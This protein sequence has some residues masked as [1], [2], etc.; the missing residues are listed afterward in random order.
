MKFLLLG[1]SFKNFRR[2][3]VKSLLYIFLIT[4]LTALLCLEL[5][6]FVSVDRFLDEA[7]DYYTTIAHYE[8]IGERYPNDNI[9]DPM[10]LEMTEKLKHSD[11]YLHDAVSAWN[12]PST[13]LTFI[14]KSGSDVMPRTVR[15][16]LPYR[17]EAVLM[18]D[19]RNTVNPWNQRKAVI[20]ATLFSH[21]DNTGKMINIDENGF[22]LEP[23]HRYLVHGYF[24][25]GSTSE[26]YFRLSPFD[27]DAA[28]AAA[29]SLE[30]GSV[31]ASTERDRVLMDLGEDAANVVPEAP[32][33]E[34]IAKSYQLTNHSLSLIPTRDLDAEWAF[35]Q[36]RLTITKG[37][38]FSPEDYEEG[39]AVVLL[40]EEV[41]G[42]LDLEIGDRIDLAA[43]DREASTILES[44]WA[45]Q[46]FDIHETVEVI[47][48]FNNE[49]DFLHHVYVPVSETFSFKH[50]HYGYSLGTAVIDNARRDEYFA[51]V[52]DSLPP[53]VRLTI[54]DQGYAAVTDSFRDIRTGT[55]LV[56]L[57]TALAGSLILLLFAYMSIYRERENG[58]VLI[59]LG[60]SY[61][62]VLRFFH[63]LPAFAASIAVTLGA[64]VGF[65]YAGEVTEYV[66]SLAES[67]RKA[68]LRYSMTNLSVTRELPFRAV[69]T[70]D[71]FTGTAVIVF[72]AAMI[73]CF[74]FAVKSMKEPKE[75]RRK[76]VRERRVKD[77]SSLSGGAVSY[78]LL[79]I[80]RSGARAVLPMGAVLTA[81][82]LL[83]GMSRSLADTKAQ[84]K[85][86]N[87]SNEIR[88]YYTNI[89]GQENKNLLVNL[90]SL[91]AIN[92]SGL[93]ES[94]AV[95]MRRNY[96]YQGRYPGGGDEYIE[97]PMPEFGNTGFGIETMMDQ[98]AEQPHI[99]FTNDMAGASD[100]YYSSGVE[101]E[102][103][104]GWSESLFAMT[105]EDQLNPK[106]GLIPRN[107][108]EKYEIEYGDRIRL[109][110]MRPHSGIDFVDITVVGSYRGDGLED[111]IYMPLLNLVSPLVLSAK[112]YTEVQVP[113][114]QLIIPDSF[115]I[116]NLVEFDSALFTLLS[117]NLS[118]FKS[119]LAEEGFSQ[120]NRLG[121][122]RQFIILSDASHLMTKASL[123]QRVNYMN[124]LYPV[125]Y[126]LTYLLAFLIPFIMLLV[127]RREIAIMKQTGTQRH[128]LFGS[129]F[130]ELL[131]LGT[132]GTILAFVLSRTMNASM[133][134][135]GINLAR[136]FFL[137]WLASTVLSTTFMTGGKKFRQIGR[138]E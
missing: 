122:L 5:S 134:T 106:V 56:L 47:G 100:F 55:I 17:Q 33:M 119:L 128:R 20:D 52:N 23:G 9:L 37:R 97:E 111:N 83:L 59:R 135:E 79:S 14:T 13:G 58:R 89:Y 126:V 66:A 54:Y 80:R 64:T 96:W 60:A 115:A 84:L 116:Q 34:A 24:Y 71:V 127:R 75:H 87:E 40:S 12:E 25:P 90:Y 110:V 46:D 112:T 62:Q 36:Q 31:S 113:G 82:L 105:K 101:T 70:R 132:T 88:A 67:S 131:I 85:E 95:T 7:N 61:A 30:D 124:I 11:A 19:V 50:G 26:I 86:V 121:K 1:H 15:P 117:G 77:S 69:T 91:Q 45:G 43:S 73:F 74:F 6:V 104:D 21:R 137:C 10:T 65:Y 38:G 48:I 42:Q 76:S 130:W 103:M 98:L 8:Y 32:L 114:S 129:F 44:Y 53:L 4:A 72:L 57:V 16:V 138:N 51:A 120:V 3:P 118:E 136:N 63:Y 68:D 107:F 39:A 123:T 81:I 99:V 29:F 125:I 93:I 41:A 28:K 109:M 94:V 92:D 2:S 18:V 102:Y 22:E 49:K 27:F 35:H 108:M 133:L 78:A